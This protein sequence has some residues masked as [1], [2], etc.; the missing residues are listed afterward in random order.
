ME[1]SPPIQKKPLAPVIPATDDE[2]FRLLVQSVRD[3]AIFLLDTNGRVTSWNIGA[4]RIKG[5]SASEI[6]GKHF[7]V[8]YPRELAEAG[9]PDRELE[10][11]ARV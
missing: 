3:Y 9:I 4:E 6:I 10:D 5:Y 2:L 7:S 1:F 11:A 8:F